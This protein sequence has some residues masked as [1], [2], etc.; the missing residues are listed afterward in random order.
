MERNKTNKTIKIILMDKILKNTK[1]YIGPMSKNIVDTIISF[2]EKEDY[3]IGL[4]PSRRQ[5]EYDGGYVNSWD[6]K[7][8]INYVRDK[9][10]KILLCRDHGGIGQGKY[11]D[12]GYISLYNDINFDIVHIDPWKKYSDL[13]SVVN[14]TV[15]NI[16]FINHLSPFLVLRWFYLQAIHLVYL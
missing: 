5:V 1:F 10:N 7:E 16:K 4:I 2:C 6:T 3:N 13:N 15:D 14:E 11:Y 12:N 8:F 9:T